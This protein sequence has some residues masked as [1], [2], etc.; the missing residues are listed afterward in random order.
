[1]GY[2]VLVERSRPQ[3]IS[4]NN[5]KP[6]I[7]VV[8]DLHLG[9]GIQSTEHRYVPNE[10]FFYDAQFSRFLDE[11]KRCYSGRPEDLKLVFNGDTFDFLTVT[12]VPDDAEAESRRFRVSSFEKR[13][14]LNPSAKKS[15]YKL[16]RIVNGH[17]RFFT[18][19][20]GFVADGFRVEIIRGNHDLELFF[21]EVK[22]RLMEHLSL[23]DERL[24]LLA[25]ESRV[26]FHDWFY[27]EKGRVYIEHGNQYDA[28]NSIRYPF[29]PI[30][31]PKHHT[32][33]KDRILDYPL[34]SIFVRFF[35]NRV[36]L[37]DPYSP[38]IASFDHY[39]SFVKRY[40]LFDVWKVYKDHYPHF[41]AAIG[42][43]PN[44]G[45]TGA[46]EEENIREKEDFEAKANND[47]SRD[48]LE[49]LNTLKISPMSASK[50]N[51]VKEMISAVMRR[52]Y[53]F[54]LLVFIAV[55]L[56]V[57]VL[58]LID[59]IPGITINAF[60]T[61]L[62]TVATLAG[63]MTIWIQLDRKLRQKKGLVDPS[64]MPQLAEQIAHI[65]QVRMVLFGHT[66]MVDHRRI[67]AGKVTYA[68][69]G[70]WTAVDNPWSRFMRDA[71][72]FTFAHVIGDEVSLSRWNDDAY[73]FE[74][75]PMFV[76]KDDNVP[77]RLPSV[78]ALDFTTSGDMSLPPDAPYFNDEED[79][80]TA[81][82]E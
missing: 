62:F 61:A 35:Y 17:L 11:L 1:M 12:S 58:Q 18:A 39:L 47:I 29:H 9:E 77:D 2:T 63:V 24:D 66:H 42:S 74:D 59:K 14:G 41:A 81:D 46:D 50:G 52:G 31:P 48:M 78:S 23:L 10:D 80:S 68:N 36:R 76:F 75:V 30:L 79:A 8:S 6:D 13:F 55:F 82:E 67:D 71:R 70:T 64:K 60:L 49:S 34:G 26:G 7:V 37:L 27:L 53:R 56:W 20:A 16:D 28:G 4:S 15:V 3:H 25:I 45:S 44:V 57:G 21:P 65:T 54:L 43:A 32:S 51:V 19:L 69:A 72:R 38:R 5:A 73:R 22:Q 40:N 33:E